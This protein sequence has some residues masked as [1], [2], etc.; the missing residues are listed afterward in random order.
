MLAETA[1]GKCGVRLVQ[2]VRP[3]DR[4]ALKDLTV[5]VR[6]EGEYDASYAG[7]NTDVLP[8]DT[9]K[10]T[11]YAL[12]A[13]RR[14]EEPEPFA[15]MLAEHFLDGN[16]HLR[17]VTIDITE[18][19]WGRVSAGEKEHDHAFVRQGSESRTAQVRCDRQDAQIR[20]GIADLLVLKTSGSA[21]AGFLRDEL[22]T[23]KETHDRVLATALTATWRYDAGTAYGPAWHATRRT[24][25]ETFAN[26]ES[27]SV[28]HTLH[29]M[30][31]AVLDAFPDIADIHIVM[32][33]RHHVPV[34]LEPFGL[35][36]RNEIFVATEMPYGLIQATLRR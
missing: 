25:L 26:H 32:P 31:R 27:A 24:L 29:A 18:H 23:L 7:D 33:N 3:G 21:F 36:N 22:T 20:A 12:A 14:I 10:N 17:R 4:H 16:P 11:V 2:V 5:A 1:Y 19:L 13:R 35:E 6:F 8:T 34:D 28:Q 9:M 30:G 15:L